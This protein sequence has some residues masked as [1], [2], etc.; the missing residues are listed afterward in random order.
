MQRSSHALSAAIDRLKQGIG[1]KGTERGEFPVGVYQHPANARSMRAQVAVFGDLSALPQCD[2]VQLAFPNNSVTSISE[3][4]IAALAPSQSE[5]DLVIVVGSDPRRMRHLLRFYR[6]ALTSR[7][8]IALLQAATPPDRTMLLNA[9]FDEVCDLR[10]PIPEARARASALLHRYSLSVEHFLTEDIINSN[11][12]KYINKKYLREDFR[13]ILNTR[14]IAVLNILSRKFSSPVSISQLNT[15]LP[16]RKSLQRSSFVVL[17]SSL[18]SAINNK[19]SIRY[20]SPSSYVLEH[21][22]SA[23]N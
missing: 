4:Y 19:Y 1:A 17:I 15:C 9:G 20:C 7:P 8:K 3:S 22:R 5:F 12:I 18:R 10:M 21:S 16:N 23:R 11:D 6:M 13:L 2:W 14:Q